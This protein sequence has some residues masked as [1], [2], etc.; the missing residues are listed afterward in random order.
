MF[1]EA[2]GVVIAAAV[3]GLFAGGVVSLTA[4]PAKAGDSVKCAG[5]NKCKGQSECGTKDHGCH[6]QNSCKGKGW[7]KVKDAKECKKKGGK[8]L[9]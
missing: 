4:T 8:V 1:K 2:K 9:P 7:I 3:A 6:G 5:I